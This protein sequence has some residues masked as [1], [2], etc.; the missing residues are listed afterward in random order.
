MRWR[1]RKEGRKR[2]GKRKGSEKRKRDEKK[3]TR[4]KGS[5]TARARSI[6]WFDLEKNPE[7]RRG[8][9][10]EEPAEEK[11]RWNKNSQP[12]TVP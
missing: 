5:E 10:R 3:T 11:R 8:W 7:L 9:T 4:R 6:G 2:K 12:P 1:E